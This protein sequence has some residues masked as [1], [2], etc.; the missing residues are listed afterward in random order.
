MV[1]LSSSP[2]RVT[3]KQA[4]SLTL[5]INEL[6][7]NAMKYA[8]QDRDKGKIGIDIALTDDTICFDFRDDGPGY[9]EEILK[10]RG[11]NVGLYLIENIVRNDLHGTVT[12]YNDSGAVTALRFKLLK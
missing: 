7:T 10:L 12:I 6:A 9:P 4:N 3:P 2:V 1:E 8:L 5:V 11:H